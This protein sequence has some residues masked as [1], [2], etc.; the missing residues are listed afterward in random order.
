VSFDFLLASGGGRGA[1]A[2]GAQRPAAGQPEG[3][4][5]GEEPAHPGQGARQRS[6]HESS[7]A[8]MS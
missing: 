6:D 5:G 1:A 3:G 2:G 8:M 7:S 4:A